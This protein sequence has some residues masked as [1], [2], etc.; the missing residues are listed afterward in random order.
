MEVVAEEL[1]TE[2]G[3]V[4]DGNVVAEDRESEQHEAEL[5]PADRMVY[6]EDKTSKSMIRVC[7][8]IRWVFRADSGVTETSP[9]NDAE[10]CW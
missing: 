10:C 9:N 5:G 6:G 3:R 4:V 8:G 1:H 7:I 2:T